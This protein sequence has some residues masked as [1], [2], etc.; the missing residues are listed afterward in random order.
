MEMYIP[1]LGICQ[2]KKGPSVTTVVFEVYT[3]SLDK[4]GAQ[5]IEDM[6]C[7]GCC[8]KRGDRL[9]GD[10]ICLDCREDQG[11]IEFMAYFSGKLM[12]GPIK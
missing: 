6:G 4:L 1:G 9:K 3:D 11:E 12:N 10:Y 5:E 8:G 7:C 2:V